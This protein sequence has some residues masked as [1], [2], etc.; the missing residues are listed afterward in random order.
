M[1]WPDKI[2]IREVGPR[3]GLQNEKAILSTDKKIALIN[4]LIEAGVVAIEATSFVHP[5][6][7]PQL[8]DAEKLLE[9]L[10]EPGP[11]VIISALV[12]N[13]RGMERALAMTHTHLREVVVVVSASEAH[14]R[15]NLNRSIDESMEGLDKIC[16]M[17]AGEINV[18]GAV[19][20]AFGCPYQGKIRFD[21]VNRVVDGMLNA[22]IREITLAD[23]AGMGN[24]RQVY[25]LVT[26]LKGNHPG[27]TWSLHLHD[28]RRMGMANTVMG[29]L[30][31][32]SVLESSVGGLGGCPFIPGATGNIA[33]GETIKLLHEMG[34]DTG[35]D[36]E[37][38]NR[39]TRNIRTCLD[40]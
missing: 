17:A 37:R 19:A 3:D 2:L 23:T 14:N 9:G 6:T 1:R 34:I 31:G 8:G 4:D 40:N 39:C 33:T 16:R 11:E 7:V 10:T 35:I 20:T 24:P 5:G 21:E 27:V 18:R 36:L 12:G 22:G 15:A 29:I 13:V 30:A 25:E 32:I 26:E 28:T 38:I